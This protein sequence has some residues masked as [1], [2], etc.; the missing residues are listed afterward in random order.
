ME[1][2]KIRSCNTTLT[3][4]RAIKSLLKAST[5]FFNIVH[6]SLH[7]NLD[8]MLAVQCTENFTTDYN[9]LLIYLEII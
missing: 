9:Y 6:T 8:L 4:R 1:L 2:E 3:A 7:E 5:D